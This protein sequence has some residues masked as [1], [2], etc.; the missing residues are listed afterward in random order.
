MKRLKKIMLLT[1]IKKKKKKLPILIAFIFA[2][3]SNKRTN[4][5]FIREVALKKIGGFQFN[6]QKKI[7]FKLN[8]IYMYVN[9]KS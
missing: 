4:N 6:Y 5:I 2:I 3:N 9:K 8:I 1:F 7:F